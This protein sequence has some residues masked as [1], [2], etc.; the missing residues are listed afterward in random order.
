MWYELI[1]NATLTLALEHVKQAVQFYELK[2]YTKIKATQ[3]ESN[4][5]NE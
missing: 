3:K 2:Y 1:D 4:E 5:R